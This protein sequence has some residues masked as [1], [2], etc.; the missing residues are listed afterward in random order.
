MFGSSASTALSV[1]TKLLSRASSVSSVSL[2]S[3]ALTWKLW[4]SW[5][6]TLVRH[7]PAAPRDSARPTTSSAQ[8]NS[9]QRLGPPDT[10]L[11]C[12]RSPRPRVV[13]SGGPG[14]RL[15]RPVGTPTRERSLPQHRTD[16]DHWYSGLEPD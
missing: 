6:R 2:A 16:L 9:V 10:V 5:S 7:R 4:R 1:L 3:V 11:A 13:V 8:A 15:Y 12:A 14:M